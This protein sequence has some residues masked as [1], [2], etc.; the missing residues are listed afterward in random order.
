MLSHVTWILSD[1]V[2]RETKVFFLLNKE[3]VE[4]VL[5]FKPSW[6]E[7]GQMNV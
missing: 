7:T 3:C 4:Y 2:H 5:F 6:D 1:E